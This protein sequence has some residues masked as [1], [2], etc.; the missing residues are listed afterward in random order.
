VKQFIKT[1]TESAAVRFDETPQHGR[2]PKVRS[3]SPSSELPWAFYDIPKELSGDD[4][5]FIPGLHDLA[6][7][8]DGTLTAVFIYGRRVAGTNWRDTIY[9]A[10]PTIDLKKQVITIKGFKK[11]DYGRP[12]A[13]HGWTRADKG[14]AH[15]VVKQPIFCWSLSRA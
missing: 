2:S 5:F 3:E 1:T 7:C 9:Y 4:D 15:R 11:D 12:V 6:P 8:D 13:T 14:E 10:T